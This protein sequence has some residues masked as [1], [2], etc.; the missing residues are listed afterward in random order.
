[1]IAKEYYIL[2]GW[3]SLCQNCLFEET[4]LSTDS[5]ENFYRSADPADAQASSDASRNV[6]IET[7]RDLRDYERSLASGRLM[8]SN[9]TDLHA[10]YEL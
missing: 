7:P 8:P 1:M 5:H 2:I 4:L 9:R 6:G 3:H 10:L